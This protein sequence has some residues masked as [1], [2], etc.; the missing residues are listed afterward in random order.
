MEQKSSEDK[1][2]GRRKIW[3]SGLRRSGEEACGWICGSRPELFYITL[4]KTPREHPHSVQS[5]RYVW[6]FVTP[7]TACQLPGWHASF[8]VHHQLLELA[9]THVH[10]VS[11]AIQPSHPLS[12]PSPPA[13]NLSQHQGLFQ[14]VSSSHIQVPQRIPTLEKTV[15]CQCID[16]ITQP[17]DAN[18]LLSLA[19]QC[20]H[21]SCMKVVAMVGGMQTLTGPYSMGSHLPNMI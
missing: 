4:L 2:L 16:K 10:R 21:N 20:W 8:S 5:L 14:G 11:D 13:F 17:G 3:R 7:W 6:L 19:T 12:C 18:Q 9:Q 15:N 1:L